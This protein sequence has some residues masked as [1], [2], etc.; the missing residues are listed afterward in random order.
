MRLS[1][2]K[3]TD[4][5][6]PPMPS[7]LSVAGLVSVSNQISK[8]TDFKF[9]ATTPTGIVLAQTCEIARIAINND[10]EV[11][12]ELPAQVKQ[13]VI[14]R[15]QCA[16]FRYATTNGLDAQTDLLPTPIQMLL[17]H[18]MCTKPGSAGGIARSTRRGGKGP[19]SLISIYCRDFDYEGA[20]DAFDKKIV[21]SLAPLDER[22]RK[23]FE[24][25]LSSG[26]LSL[27]RARDDTHRFFNRC[28]RDYQN[29]A[30]RFYLGLHALNP[31][32]PRLA[33]TSPHW[34]SNS[35]QSTR[36]EIWSAAATLARLICLKV[37]EAARDR[38][39]KLDFSANCPYPTIGITTQKL[40][41][42]EGN[43]Q[44]IAALSSTNT[45]ATNSPPMVE[46]Q[47][48]D[49]KKY[50]YAHIGHLGEEGN[51][52]A[53]A[54]VRVLNFL[55]VSRLLGDMGRAERQNILA[56]NQMSSSAESTS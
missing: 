43:Q 52:A 21:D 48:I 39:L 46:S 44:I 25:V 14:A 33:D 37:Y 38:I 40:L 3:S 13:D 7:T 53:T 23:V 24:A 20:L 18:A 54:M 51:H 30:R 31:A 49:L 5:R 42:G 17:D 22:E 1:D 27:R 47:G 12:G 56:E 10:F 16:L 28:H 8:F 50:L 6:E 2:G 4:L 29:W 26:R 34:L 55:I 9:D 11:P 19:A 35:A 15:V 45:D 41:R 36:S 32:L